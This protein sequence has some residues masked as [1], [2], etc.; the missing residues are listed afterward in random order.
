MNQ[1]SQLSFFHISLLRMKMEK[2]FPC[3]NKGNDHPSEVFSDTELVQYNTYALGMHMPLID[4][5]NKKYESI[6]NEISSHNWKTELQ[7]L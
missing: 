1:S 4:K 5:R 7:I 6:I 3:A 2:G